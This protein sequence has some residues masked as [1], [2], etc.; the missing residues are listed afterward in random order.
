MASR[1]LLDSLAEHIQRK[2]ERSNFLAYV[3][4]DVR[5]FWDSNADISSQ[6][7][8]VQIKNFAVNYGFL[9]VVD[10]KQMSA[11]FY[12]PQRKHSR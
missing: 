1:L 3:R 5:K 6:E 10:S 12:V 2:M 9:V 11:N 8:S 7:Q 4:V